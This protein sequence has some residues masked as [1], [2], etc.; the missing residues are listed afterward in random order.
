MAVR[1]TLGLEVAVASWRG[2]QVLEEEGEEKAKV[3]WDEERTK[4]CV[5][6]GGTALSRAWE[7]GEVKT[8]PGTS[9]QRAGE[10]GENRPETPPEASCWPVL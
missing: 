10:G 3:R 8:D 9:E 1:G 7:A 4:G 2:L 5:A 6:G